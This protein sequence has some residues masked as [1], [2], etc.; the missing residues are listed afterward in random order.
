MS[1]PSTTRPTPT[2]EEVEAVMD[3]FRYGDVDQGDFD[4]IKRFAERYGDDAVAELK[5][6]R[7]NSALHMAGGNGHEEIVS[8]LLPRLPVSAL[9]VQN[10]SQSTPLHWIAL[11]YHLSI[12]ERVCPLLPLD[13]FSIKN[14]H[15]KTA[16]EEAEEACEA[17]VV[18]EGEEASPRGVERVKREK[19]VGYL[20]G[21][22]GL[23]VKKPTGGD[24]S[25]AE[26]QD[27]D[28]VRAEQ[29]EKGEQAMQA[30]Q[31]QA[32][33]IKLEQEEASR[34]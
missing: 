10:S 11:N 28:V 17:L 20:L 16:V 23:G 25:K 26:E 24:D 9:S 12:L 30:L 18:P 27:G 1:A 13:A 7:G 3:C 19:V 21:C 2:R 32:E 22:M 5:D 33:R 34:S 29:G 31:E 6:D 14:K 4:D 15:G 8:W